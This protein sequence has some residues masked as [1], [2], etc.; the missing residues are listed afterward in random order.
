MDSRTRTLRALSGKPTDRIPI[1]FWAT[2]AVIS[3]LETKL[4]VDYQGF[5]DR[6]DVDLRYI[7][8]PEYIGPPLPPGSDIWGVKRNQVQAGGQARAESYSELA[9]PPL[10][11]A[12]TVAD[13]ENYRHWP[14]PDMFDYSVIGRQCDLIKDEKRIAVFMGDRLNR[15]AQ[16]KPAMYL[17]GM[18]NLFVDLAASPDLA[19]A[20]IN[21]IRHFYLAYLD[22]ILEA[23]EGKIDIVLT[24]DD[25]GAQNGLLVSADM[26]RRFVKPGFAAYL[27]LIASHQTLSMHHTCGS[28]VEIIPDFITCGLDVLQ[29]V[30]PE[31]KGM[32]ASVLQREFGRDICF[33]GGVSIQRTMP[34]GTPE[35]IFREVRAL[36]G[37][38]RDAGGY[39]LCTSHNIQGD[40]PLENV[41]AL[42]EAYHKS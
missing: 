9:G 13:I 18:E 16:L 21:R 19:Q 27:D 36:S 39:I 15:I 17:R 25:F 29:S 1:D 30:Q 7:A 38:F 12:E 34:H 31:A 10:A 33:H 35:D 14:D 37:V 26:W 3:A 23:A 2:P 6:Y 4:E 8:G 28:V 22:R 42:M 24:G 11:G 41:I 40:T 5:L 32:S 20:L